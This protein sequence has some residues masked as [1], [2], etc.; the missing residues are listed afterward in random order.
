MSTTTNQFPLVSYLIGYFSL[1]FL[2]YKI[3]VIAIFRTRLCVDFDSFLP[4]NAALTGVA[5]N[6]NIS[7][8][9]VMDVLCYL[10]VY[11]DVIYGLVVQ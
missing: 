10:G 4:H 1:I 8:P 9:G 7:P 2:K 6:C 5:V 3:L 11:E